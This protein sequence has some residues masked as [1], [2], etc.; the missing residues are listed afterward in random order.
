MACAA[1][2]IGQHAADVGS[3]PHRA[4]V[5]ADRGDRAFVV[6]VRFQAPPV[7]GDRFDF[8]GLTWEVTRPRTV[9]RGLVARPVRRR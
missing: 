3:G 9:Q 5:I 8:Q 1:H 2:E 7:V 4:L 6:A